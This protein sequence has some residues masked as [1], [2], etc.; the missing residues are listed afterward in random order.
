LAACTARIPVARRLLARL[1]GFPDW[2]VFLGTLVQQYQ[3]VGN[4]VPP[5]LA[6]AVGRSVLAARYLEIL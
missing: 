3:Q 6:A 1:Q 5:P 2:F 4:A